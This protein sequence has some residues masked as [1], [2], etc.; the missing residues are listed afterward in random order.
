LSPSPAQVWKPSPWGQSL[1]SFSTR[2]P[3]SKSICY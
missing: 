1:I 2:A 3:I